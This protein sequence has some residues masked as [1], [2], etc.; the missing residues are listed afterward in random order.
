MN[1]RHSFI[2]LISKLNPREPKS[3]LDH[4]HLYNRCSHL[5]GLTTDIARCELINMALIWH[6]C[7]PPVRTSGRP[8]YQE[9]G[10]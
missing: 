4:V 7:I 8:L 5:A 6:D 3:A 1:L 2:E 9:R 10:R